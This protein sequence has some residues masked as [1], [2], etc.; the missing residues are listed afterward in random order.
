MVKT[1]NEHGR[2]LGRWQRVKEGELDPAEDPTEIKKS[3]QEAAKRFPKKAQEY[4]LKGAP[5]ASPEMKVL[6]LCKDATRRRFIRR[7]HN[8]ETDPILSQGLGEDDLLNEDHRW[9]WNYI[10]TQGFVPV[11]RRDE[12]RGRVALY[13]GLKLPGSVLEE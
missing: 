11:I 4:F 3:A 6:D 2:A 9:L 7:E 5:P 8:D 1:R 13:A 12:S 10:R